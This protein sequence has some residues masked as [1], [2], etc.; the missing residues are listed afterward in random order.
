MAGNTVGICNVMF[1]YIV[2]GWKISEKE[3]IIILL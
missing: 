3:R 2:G 1:I